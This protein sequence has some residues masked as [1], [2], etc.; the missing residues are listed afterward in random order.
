MNTRKRLS[1]RDKSPEF[2][3]K[4]KLKSVLKEDGPGQNKQLRLLTSA[5][6]SSLTPKIA[7]G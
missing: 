1:K 5:T 4:I 3:K 7:T 6:G 2:S